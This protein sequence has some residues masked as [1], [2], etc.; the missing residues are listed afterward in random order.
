MARAEQYDTRKYDCCAPFHGEIGE[1]FTR[2]FRPEFEGALHSVVDNYAS[3]YEHVVLQ[4]DPGSAADPPPAG[5]AGEGS[6]RAFAQR[7][8]RSF[9]LIRKHI[10]DPALRDEIDA[11]AMGDGP[12][13]WA[14]IVARCTRPQTYLNL[15]DQDN[16]WVLTSITEVGFNERTVENYSAL[17]S[18]INRER[19]VAQR[20]TNVQVWQKLL[21]GIG[22]VG[23]NELRTIVRNEMQNP[24]M[25]HPAGHA[26]AGQPSIA[27][28][29]QHL[30]LNAGGC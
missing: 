23:N 22:A 29:V 16:E 10:E 14:I 7:Q 28:Y 27:L 18:R 21:E 20:K 3:L 19:P 4:T 30:W 8:K 15:A 6:R 11:N 1:E 25:V 9:G 12:A 5:A 17:L 2:R 24:T 13:A 26:D